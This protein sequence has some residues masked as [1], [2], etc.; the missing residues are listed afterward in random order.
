MLFSVLRAPAS[1]SVLQGAFL[2]SQLTSF[3]CCISPPDKAVSPSPSIMKSAAVLFATGAVAASCGN[4][5]GYL[6]QMTDSYIRKG[7]PFSFHYGE[8]TLYSGIE[9]AYE[10]GHND[11]ISA[12]LESQVNGILTDDGEIRNWRPTH[13]SL[14]DYRIGNNLL[15]LYERHGEEKYA[16][17]AKIIRDQ[18][19]E[20]H[21][22]TPLGGFWHR[23]PIYANQMWLDGIFMA[24]TFYAKYTSLFDKDNATA[25][26]D[27][28]HQSVSNTLQTVIESRTRKPEIELLVHG[29][30]ESKTAIWADP[31][32]GA[33]PLVWSRAVGWYY[34]SL[35][36]VLQII[37]KETPGY[38]RL[39]DYFVRLSKG[40]KASQ[41]PE[42]GW[43]LLMDEQYLDD[44]RNYLE[45]SASAMFVTG[46]LR[47]IRLG[48]LD[49][50][51]Y[52]PA[53]EFGYKTLVD[54]WVTE[55][56]NNGTIN[57]EGTVQVGSLNSNATIE[58]YTSI[59]IVRNDNR[60]GG[61]Y[62]MAAYEWE[63]RSEE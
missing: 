55:N 9:L 31:E 53:G 51:E 23:A 18:L 14:D 58:Y 44:P 43:Y 7:W 30:D 40:A 17:A 57:W 37:P 20:R 35:T 29:Y 11:T 8:A 22:R 19:V 12:W 16:K 47:G 52:L 45:S 41:D 13:Y 26:Q 38:E 3:G 46:L 56:P 21:P 62:L 36:E 28:I 39:V 6:H 42:G 33:S 63:V 32:T 2:P 5:E 24:D 50:K 48:F 27:I 4:Y 54:R 15:W 34:V 59:P 61:A 60:G 10:L 25:W 1:S 49:E